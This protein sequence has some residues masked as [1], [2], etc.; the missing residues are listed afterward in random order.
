MSFY[1][2]Y[3]MFLKKI[4]RQ[5]LVSSWMVGVPL[6]ERRPVR[7]TNLSFY[8][9]VSLLPICNLIYYILQ[10]ECILHM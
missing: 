2:S 8:E 4:S 5:N 9:R 7:Y 1:F 10:S 3:K 6:D